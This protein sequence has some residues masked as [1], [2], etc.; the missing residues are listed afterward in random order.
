M[1]TL[2]D[3]QW[4]AKT[5]DLLPK[6]VFTF[7][8]QDL[9]EHLIDVFFRCVNSFLPILHRPTFEASVR[10]GFHLRDPSVGAVVLLLCAAASR[11]SDDPRVLPQ[12]L[13]DA[14][15]Q[16]P[17]SAAGWEF[18]FQVHA[19]YR[20][21]LLDTTTTSV[22]DLQMMAVSVR[23]DVDVYVSLTTNY[24]VGLP[25]PSRDVDSFAFLANGRSWPPFSP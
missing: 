18:Y 12:S 2:S 3:T 16:Q 10:D 20:R 9:L 8:P 22:L 6:I 13:T 19:R 5:K 11:W 14:E 7:P 1:L 15:E 25:L 4:E 21:N 23:L 24:T 17:W